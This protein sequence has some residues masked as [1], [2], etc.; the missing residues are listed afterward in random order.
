MS[1]FK[2]AGPPAQTNMST[3]QNITK[4]A[5][6]ALKEAE[7]LDLFRRSDGRLVLRHESDGKPAETPIRVACC[8]PWAHRE[9]L[10]SL[11][12][13]KGRELRLIE[14]LAQLDGNARQLVA[15]ELN[16]AFFVPLIIEVKSIER[17][18]ELFLWRVETNAGPRN[19]LTGH[20][21][22]PRTLPNGR[23]LIRDVSNDLYIIDDPKTLNA[24]SCKLL[25]SYL[26]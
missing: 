12:D 16:S 6:T 23:I 17:Q 11:R 10:I 7:R 1:P 25:W 13:D 22:R 4:K 19:F 18:A 5:D 24:K 3:N 21:E 20:D 26:D 2:A 15:E 9:E 8:F 14:N